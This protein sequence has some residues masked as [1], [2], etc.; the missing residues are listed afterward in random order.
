LTLINAKIYDPCWLQIIHAVATLV[1]L[2]SEDIFRALDA[3]NVAGDDASTSLAPSNYRDE[4]VA[5]FFV[6][7]G[8]CFQTLVNMIN[9]DDSKAKRTIPAVLDALKR[10]LRPSI[11]GNAMYKGFV[12]AE[13]TDLLDRLVL[14][15][16]SDVQ[17]TVIHIAA[18]LAKYHPNGMYAQSDGR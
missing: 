11:S 16:S 8:L 18:S 3:N 12:F 5:F 6:I 15:E 10:F 17:L 13:T 14:M 4:P 9:K 7:Y 2:E 1:E